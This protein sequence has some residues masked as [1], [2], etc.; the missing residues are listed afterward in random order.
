MNSI[1]ASATYSVRN[2]SSK[3]ATRDRDARS[4]LKAKHAKRRKSRKVICT[5]S[6]RCDSCRRRCS[7]IA[8]IKRS[9]TYTHRQQRKVLPKFAQNVACKY[10]SEPPSSIGHFRQGPPAP[11]LHLL[12]AEVSASQ[13]HATAHPTGIK[14]ASSG[15]Q[16]PSSYSH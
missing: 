9:Q 6:P 10:W 7:C 2:P 8:S 1:A 12:T 13:G 11:Q 3:S 16:K 5:W 4:T 15:W 14:M